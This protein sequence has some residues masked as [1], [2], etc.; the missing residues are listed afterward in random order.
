MDA[1]GELEEEVGECRGSV[2]RRDWWKQRVSWKK[3]LVNAE[4]QL[5]EEVG[6]YRGSVGRRGW[7][8]QRVTEI[9]LEGER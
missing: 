2:G 7:W 6:G 4:G 1:E 5:E 3:R 8:M 9:K